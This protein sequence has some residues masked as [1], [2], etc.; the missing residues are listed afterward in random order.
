M[1]SQLE[2]A[3]K[4]LNI[5]ALQF[6]G[7]LGVNVTRPSL[8]VQPGFRLVYKFDTGEHLRAWEE[9][10]RQHA[11]VEEANRYTQGAPRYEILTGLESWFTL[12]SVSGLQPP[13]RG[14][15]TLVS[16]LGIFPLVYVYGELLHHLL[17]DRTP[18][19]LRVAAVT[20][21]VVPTMSYV[22]APRLT[23]L[24]KEWLYPQRS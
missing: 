18:S 5:A 14:K 17:P 3:I 21:L 6:P 23:R 10:D 13:P 12:P 4:N 9:S 1:E 15:M 8:P 22:V 20:L 7:H 2:R 19:M 11:L 24:F 16:W